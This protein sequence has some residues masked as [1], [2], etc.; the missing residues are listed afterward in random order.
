MRRVFR[1]DIKELDAKII[2]R[3]WH[4]PT[5][6]ASPH[7]QNVVGSYQTVPFS[8]GEAWH[9]LIGYIICRSCRT[10]RT[11]RLWSIGHHRFGGDQQTCDRSG[12]L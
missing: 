5:W 4:F 8:M 9:V 11:Q 12:I 2:M 7:Q 1:E 10:A 3:A 6:R